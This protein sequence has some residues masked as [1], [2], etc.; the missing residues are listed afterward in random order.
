MRNEQEVMDL[1]LS[2]AKSDE[3]VRAVLRID[4]SLVPLNAENLK[5]YDCL[6]VTL[7]KVQD[8][9][10]IVRKRGLKSLRMNRLQ[11]VRS[12]RLQ[13]KTMIFNHFGFPFRII[14]NA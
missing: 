10:L 4:L 14:H 7:K 1:I 12:G 11:T 5:Q 2:V 6:T 8:I 13:R 3:R 9:F